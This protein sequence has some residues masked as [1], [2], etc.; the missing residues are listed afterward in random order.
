M[1]E[2]AEA[3]PNVANSTRTEKEVQIADGSMKMWSQKMMIR[4]YTDIDI[5]PAEQVMIE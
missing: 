1:V 5:S 2:E 3:L 4:L